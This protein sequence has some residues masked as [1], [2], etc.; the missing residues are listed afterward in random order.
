M[1]RCLSVG[2]D[3]VVKGQTISGT[4]ASPNDRGA[5]DDRR[6]LALFRKAEFARI[7]GHAL[8]V[9]YDPAEPS[10]AYLQAA[11][12]WSRLLQGL[13]LGAAAFLMAGWFFARAVARQPQREFHH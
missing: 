2:F 10:R 1:D 4:S 6:L 8:P 5:A 13:A 9:T 7:T 11:V 3:L 12:P